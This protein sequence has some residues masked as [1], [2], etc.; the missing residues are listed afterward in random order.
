[1][2]D[3]EELSLLETQYR[4]M[5]A[6]GTGDVVEWREGSKSLRKGENALANLQARIDRLR[7]RVGRQSLGGGSVT[8]DPVR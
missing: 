1:M 8:L 6:A 7:S 4:A 2:T 3:Q 5:L